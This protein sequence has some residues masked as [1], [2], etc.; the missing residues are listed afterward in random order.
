[1][2][3][4]FAIIKYGE[5]INYDAINLDLSDRLNRL[6]IEIRLGNFSTDLNKLNKRLDTVEKKQDMMSFGSAAN[7]RKLFHFR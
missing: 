6:I 5:Q 7:S 1:M 3:I 2:M 4:F